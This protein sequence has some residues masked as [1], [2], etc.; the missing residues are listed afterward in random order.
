MAI[1]AI[2][3]AP[4]PGKIVEMTKTEEETRSSWSMMAAHD[5][6]EVTSVKTVTNTT[7]V[8][9]WLRPDGTTR[10]ERAEETGTTKGIEKAKDLRVTSASSGAASHS[11]SKSVSITR[12]APSRWSASV[13]LGTDLSWRRQLGAHATARVLGPVSVGAWILPVARAG[14]LSVGFAF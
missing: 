12:Q 9:R 14:G 11:E 10:K 3:L 4:K 13:L 7:I 6:R 8:T 1:G 5:G 2:W